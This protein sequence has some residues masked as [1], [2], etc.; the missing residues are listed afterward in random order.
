MKKNSILILAMLV[1]GIRSIMAQNCIPNPGFEEWDSIPGVRPF[2]NPKGYTSK[3]GAF[4]NTNRIYVFRST[5]SHSGNYSLLLTPAI[6]SSLNTS[7]LNTWIV[8]DTLKNRAVSS[9]T[10][11]GSFY[12][13]IPLPSFPKRLKGFY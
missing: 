1:I 3:N 5:D 13:P 2:W 9:E 10:H 7:T 4:Q 12:A 6:D 11:L 8:S